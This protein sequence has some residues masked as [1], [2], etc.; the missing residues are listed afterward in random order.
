[1]YWESVEAV[2]VERRNLVTYLCSRLEGTTMATHDVML[3]PLPERRVAL[4]NRH[5]LAGD[6]DAFLNEAF[7]AL[8]AAGL[9]LVGIAGCPFLVFYGEVSEDSDGPIEL[10]R[11][12]AGSGA[13]AVDAIETR[14]EATHDEMYVRLSKA[15]LAWPAMRA[16]LDDLETWARE[17]NRRPGATSRQVPIADQRTA[18]ADTPVCDLSVPL[19]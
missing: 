15:E 17:N 7:P 18:T 5:V 6:A 16:A 14:D 13:V 3:R 9:G 10:C 12:I 4:I 19:R 1:M 8:R 2:S 11:P